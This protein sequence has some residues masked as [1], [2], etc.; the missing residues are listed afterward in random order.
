MS[1]TS[2][3]MRDLEEAAAAGSERA[4]TAIEIYVAAVR[5]WLGAGMVE[6]GGL[7]AIG[8]AGG[9]GE[10][11]PATRAAVLAGLGDLGIAIDEQ[12]NLAA[13]GGER[14]I[15]AAGSATA[16]W[17]IPTNEELVVARQ[18][19]DLLVSTNR[20]DQGAPERTGG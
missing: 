3:D 19:R 13:G 14:P 4:A 9:I 7:D 6:L 10:H 18:T 2:G 20:H 16:V 12:A 8:F 5:H 17:I 1:G 15:A 11:S